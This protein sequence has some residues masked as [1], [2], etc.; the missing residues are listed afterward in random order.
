MNINDDERIENFK[1][2]DSDRNELKWT[3]EPIDIGIE[4]IENIDDGLSLEDLKWRD[5]VSASFEFEYLNI[6]DYLAISWLDVLETYRN[7]RRSEFIL[8]FGDK[9]KRI[10]NF[11]N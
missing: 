4:D 11:K 9:K 7:F 3:T 8:R 1:I 6:Y 5:S 10:K 2:Y